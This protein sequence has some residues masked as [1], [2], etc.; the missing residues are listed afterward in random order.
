[1]VPHQKK[2]SPASYQSTENI[3]NLYKNLLKGCRRRS[4]FLSPCKTFKIP[5]CLPHPHCHQWCGS[6]PSPVSSPQSH[7]P[8]QFKLYQM[9]PELEL[10]LLWPFLQLSFQSSQL[11]LEQLSAAPN[12]NHIASQ[13][14]KKAE[15]TGRAS[16]L[17]GKVSSFK[18]LLW[19]LIWQAVFGGTLYKC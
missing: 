6:S 18:K 14:S 8:S 5:L 15:C 9:L 10:A 11:S 7:H 4:A 16:L 2:L 13:D 3:L 12:W 19:W 17:G 1:M